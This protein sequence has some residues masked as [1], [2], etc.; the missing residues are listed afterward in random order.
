MRSGFRRT[1]VCAAAALVAATV[2]PLVGAAAAE[3]APTADGYLQIVAH[4]DDDILFMNPDL[5]RQ[6]SAPSTTV[7]LTSGEQATKTESACL[8]AQH[9]E[10][11]AR[12]AHARLA[13]V[14]DDWDFDTLTLGNG[15]TV[16][17]DTLRGTPNPVRL[18]F[19]R[20]YQS[21][22]PGAPGE[23]SLDDLYIGP[24]PVDG[25]PVTPNPKRTLGSLTSDGEECRSA[26]GDPRRTP[27]YRPFGHQTYTHEELVAALTDLMGRYNP[28]VL[29]A[30]DPKVYP[31][32]RGHDG[33]DG[34]DYRTDPLNFGDNSDHRG[35]ARFAGEAAT[36]YH[37]AQGNVLLRYYRD[38]N[39]RLRPANVDPRQAAAKWSVFRDGYL[40]HDS[41]LHES[42]AASWQNHYAMYEYRSYPR[43]FN[44]TTWSAQDGNGLLNA[45]A[46]VNGQPSQWKE[47]ATGGAWTGPAGLG[48]GGQFAPYL[49]VAKDGTGLLHLFGI[50]LADDRGRNNHDEVVTLAQTSVGGG[51][52]AWTSLGNPNAD[53]VGEMI[54]S[55]VV[56][57]N[58]DGA[59]TVFVPNAGG[60][61]S[62][63]TQQRNGTWPGG[64]DD[65]RGAWVQDGLAASLGTDGL[66]DLFAPTVTGQGGILHWRQS[67]R[68]GPFVQDTAFSAP[69]PAGP[70]GVARTAGGRK[71]ILFSHPD[72]GKTVNQWVRDDRMW[73]PVS[74]STGGPVSVDGPAVATAN[75]RVVVATRNGG[76]GLSLA[77]QTEADGAFTTVWQDL[78]SV[79]VG[80][81]SLATDAT[82]R[83]VVLALGTDAQLHL[84]RQS[85]A[86][87]DSP[88]AD[89]QSAVS[90]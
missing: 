56:S 21:G 47:T 85:D 88:F 83:V 26:P 30:Q 66:I 77:T 75:G 3:T 36:G 39:I 79:I 5:A 49:T 1:A 22:D 69:T 13:G 27:D 46:V 72:T 28:S 24:V 76:G 45:F 35:A 84:R 20:L 12:E 23:T 6:Y 65:L 57:A 17:L 8:Y 7:Y 58:A 59:L 86:R 15:K 81:P 2:T 38:Y 74:S 14:A 42:G 80:A 31:L 68:N 16:E 64:W 51:W 18:V 54:G 70:I 33:D 50:R 67:T 78:G 40:P 19:F 52:G 82:G 10:E 73:T 4:Q 55:P 89:W 60:G 32:G 62:A 90:S 25:K 29:L 71:E 44:G 11:G 48:G 63:V 53:D 61:V 9:R 41:E 34:Y 43:W 37:P 87:A